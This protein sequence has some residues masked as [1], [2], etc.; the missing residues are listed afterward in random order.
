MPNITMLDIDE[1]RQTKLKP[2]IDKCLINAPAEN[3]PGVWIDWHGMAL[4]GYSA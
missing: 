1:L 2:Y 3:S 4:I